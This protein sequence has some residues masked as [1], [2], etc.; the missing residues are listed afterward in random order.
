MGLRY[1]PR[2]GDAMGAAAAR[3]ARD[4]EMALALEPAIDSLVCFTNEAREAAGIS[5]D[6]MQHLQNMVART[7][8]P[9]P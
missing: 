4:K 3:D 7:L 2:A 6:L 5:S 1:A 8:D 9:K